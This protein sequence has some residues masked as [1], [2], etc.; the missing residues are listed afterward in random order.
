MYIDL[1]D[2]FW[3]VI[4]VIGGAALVFIIITLNN[5]T[6]LIKNANNLIEQNKNNINTLCN[7]LPEI[8]DNITEISGNVKDISD[9]ATEV[10]AEAIVAKD[11]ILSNYETAKDILNIILSIFTK[12]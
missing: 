7:K 3:G 2:L 5:L 8:S 9:V 11:S 4:G 10:T 6:K 1:W 12:K